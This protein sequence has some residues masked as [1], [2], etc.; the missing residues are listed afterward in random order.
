MTHA[1]NVPTLTTEELDQFELVL[2]EETIDIYNYVS[3]KDELPDHLRS[4]SLMKKLQTYAL[5]GNMASPEGYAAVKKS[6]NLT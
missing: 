5:T 2:F 1:E 6:T 3:G 4:L